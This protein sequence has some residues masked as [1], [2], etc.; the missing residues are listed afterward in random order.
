ML[1]IIKKTLRKGYSLLVKY[2]PVIASK[3]IYF[4]FFGKR[5]NLRNPVTFNEKLM[6]LKLYEDD[7]LKTMCADKYLVRNYIRQQGYSHLLIE[8]YDVYEIVEQIKFEEIPNRFVMKCTHASGFNIICADKEKMDKKQI[9]SQLKK[10]MET[11]YSLIYCEPHYSNIKPRIIVEKFLNEELY[12]DLPL[13]FKI[14]CF[15]GEPQIIEII[16]PEDSS[17]KRELLFNCDWD[18]LPYNDDSLNF[19]GAIKKP[20]KLN[21]MVDISRNLSKAFTYV[22]VDL[23]YCNNKIYFGELTFTPGACLDL[24]FINDTDY[25]LGNL[26]DLTKLKMDR[27]RLATL[28]LDLK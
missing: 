16:V 8:L 19:L 15:H 25:L 12:D 21:E 13:D 27:K 24:D 17:N 3:L 20:E 4:K 26:L 9:T 14:H 22:R 18:L 2:S 5:L 10:W 23:Y 28:S 7:L 11:D 6:W 1:S